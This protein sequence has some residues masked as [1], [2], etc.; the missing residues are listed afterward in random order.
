MLQHVLP[1]VQS[2]LPLVQNHEYWKQ[3]GTEWIKHRQ[4]LRVRVMG[5]TFFLE[6]AS[7]TTNINGNYK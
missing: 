3:I 1:N 2:Q 4:A 5:T 7:S 6:M